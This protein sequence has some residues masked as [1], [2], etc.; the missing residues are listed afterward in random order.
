M[1]NTVYGAILIEK[2]QAI[3]SGNIKSIKLAA[4]PLEN[5]SVFYADSLVSGERE[6]YQV[7]IPATAALATGN[8]LIHASVP[9][10][11]L[12][13]Y[14]IVN[15]VLEG[16]KIGRAYVPSIGDVFTISDSVISGT[17]T[18]DQF[19]IPADGTF[20]LTASS[21]IGSTKFSARVLSK[22]TLF[23]AASTTFE[24]VKA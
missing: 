13:G 3:R 10:N 17:T 20:K 8:L 14:T 18:V 5:G 7:V 9:T 24:V 15:Y 23:G 19:L 6:V 11:Y 4:T 12:A 21:T 22:G 1:S 16:G 2:C